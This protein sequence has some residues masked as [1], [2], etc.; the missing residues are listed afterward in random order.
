M[1]W[2]HWYAAKS[3]VMSALWL[4]PLV[5]FVMA[6]LTYRVPYVLGIDLGAISGLRLSVRSRR[7]RLTSR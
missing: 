6:Q 3:Y 7:W 2:G 1:T 4:S 5:A